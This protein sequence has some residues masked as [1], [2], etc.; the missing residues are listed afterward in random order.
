VNGEPNCVEVGNVLPPPV[1]V[2]A[3]S[4]ATLN[5]GCAGQFTLCFQIKAGDV[6][7]P[8]ADDCVVT[9]QCVDVWYD[10]PGSDMALPALTPWTSTDVACSKRFI[11]SGGYGETTVLGRTVECEGIDDGSGQPIV[12]FRTKYCP[13]GAVGCQTGGSG[14]F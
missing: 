9:R 4:E 1:P 8:G 6:A 5:V 2:T 3:W 7:H 14:D 13:V 12:F 11:D 10:T